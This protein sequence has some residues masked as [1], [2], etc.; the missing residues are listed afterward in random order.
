MS[1]IARAGEAADPMIKPSSH[2]RNDGE[3]DVCFIMPCYNEA[4]N[5]GYTVPKLLDA[6][7][8]AGHRIQ[9]ITVNNGSADRTGEMLAELA[10]RFPQISVVTVERNI[11]YG[12]G[13]L[14]GLPHAAAPWIGTVA[15]DGQ[16]DAEDVV[17]LYEAVSVTRTPTFGKVRRRFR[18]DGPIRKVISVGYNVFVHLLWPGIG[19]LDV[20]GNPRLLPR[21]VVAAMELQATNWF[22]DPEMLIKAH[23]MGVRILELNVFARMR[24]NG[25][26]HVRASTCWE[27]FR[28]LLQFRFSG[29]LDRWRHAVRQGAPMPV[30]AH[31]VPAASD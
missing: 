30:V 21:D 14:N 29:D 2:P 20:N 9:L 22:L 19:S 11:G 24:G 5:V 15:A 31:S 26:S 23:Y 8:Q 12:N 7:T 16:V 13:V 27:F 4:E 25:L 3:A 1:P 18:M 10:G 6:F 28:A 17:R